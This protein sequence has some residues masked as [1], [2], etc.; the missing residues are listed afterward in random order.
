MAQRLSLAELGLCATCNYMELCTSRKSWVGPIIHCENFDDSEPMERPKRDAPS[1]RRPASA[2]SRA[3]KPP[4]THKGLCVNCNARD[5]CSLKQSDAIVF[6]CEEYG[7]RPLATLVPDS[8]LPPFSAPTSSA[9]DKKRSQ[10]Q[11]HKHADP[12]V[13]SAI[14][15]K[16]EGAYGSLITILEEIQSEFGYLPQEALALVAEKT[17]RPLVD[18]YGIATFYRAFSLRPKGRHL[19]SVC[20]GTACHVRGAPLIVGEFEQRL[21]VK[22]GETTADY[23]FTLETV[24]CLGACALGPVVVA[25]TNY[26]SKVRQAKIDRILTKVRRDDVA[27]LSDDPRVFPL[28]LHCPHCAH[29]LLDTGH[30]IDGHPSV[31]LTARFNGSPSSVRLSSLYGSYAVE[32]EYDFPLNALVT[33][34]CSHCDAELTCPSHCPDCDSPM[35]SLSVAPEGTLRVCARRGCKSHMLDLR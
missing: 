23:E 6:Y 34:A 4:I 12:A 5:Y 18:I 26:F 19:V 25:D 17:R 27:Q 10:A 3:S 11:P 29:T 20:L 35:F 8:L 22:P 15:Q 14:I 24:N 32:S 16:N 7:V 21:G 33:F 31:H 2:P 28:T 9:A 1:S 30:L 13:V